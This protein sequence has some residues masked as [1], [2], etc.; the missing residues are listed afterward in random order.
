MRVFNTHDTSGGNVINVAGD[1]TTYT[2]IV[3]NLL[4]KSYAEGASWNSTL[5]CLPG[6]RLEILSEIAA[7]AHTPDSQNVLWLEDV[8]GSGK[9]AIAHTIAQMLHDEGRLASSFFFSRDIASL[10]NPRL[11][12]TTIARDI[13]ALD[14]AIA[15][16]ISNTLE[17][18]PALAF[19]DLS[20]QFEALIAGPLSRSGRQ[21]PFIVVIDAL[22]EGICN[23]VDTH[24]LH[25]LCHNVPRLASRLCIFITSRPTSIIVQFIQNS[26][27]E[28]IKK[29]HINIHSNHNQTDIARYVDAQLRE[30]TIRNVM[31]PTSADE[32]VIRSL[33]AEGLFIWIVTIFNYLR[34][35]GTYRPI[36]K[37][38]ALLSKSSSRGV[39][40]PNKKMDELYAAILK[41]SGDWDDAE[42]R[43]DYALLMGAIISVKRPLSLKALRALHGGDEDLLPLALLQRFGSVLGLHGETEPIHILHISFREFITDCAAPK[44]DTRKYHICEKEHSQR[45]AV[46]CL[47]TMVR[48]FSGHQAS[49]TGYLSREDADEEVCSAEDY[50]ER[51]PDEDDV[52]SDEEKGRET[53]EKGSGVDKEQDNNVHDIGS[54]NKGLPKV[55]EVPEQLLY[56]CESWIG[57]TCDVD[58]PNDTLAEVI[59]EFLLHHNTMWI[60]IVSS[61]SVFRGSLSMLHWLEAH[62]P[63]LRELYDEKSQASA[64][65]SLSKRFAYAGRLEEALTAIQESVYLYELLVAKQPAIFNAGLAM[66]MNS[67]SKCL[68]EV[69]KME[70]ALNA[71][72]KAVDLHR[73]LSLAQTGG[74]DAKLASSLNSLAKTRATLGHHE[75][76]LTAAKESVDLLVVLAAEQPMMFNADLAMT[77]N[78]MSFYLSNLG[79]DEEALPAAEDSVDLYRTLA[80]QRPVK[81][82]AE[83]ALSLNGFS[84]IL[85]TLGR[86]AEALAEAQESVNLYRTL[87]AERPSVFND[88][89][90]RS[91][92]N[93]SARLSDFGRSE[94]ALSAI[95]EAVRLHRNLAAERPAKFNGDLATSLDNL[96]SALSNLGR[97][98][99]ALAPVQEAVYLCR[100]LATER[101]EAFNGDLARSL[102]NVSTCLDSLGRS[103][104]AFPAAQEAVNL[105][106]A[107][108]VKRPAK[109]RPVLAMSLNSLSGILSN[110]G[111][112][113]AALKTI[114]ESVFGCRALAAQRPSVFNA[115]LARSL[116]NMSVYLANLGRSED[117]LLVI[118]ESVFLHRHLAT[119]RPEKYNAELA[120]ALNGLSTVLSNMSWAEAALT[121]VLESVDLRRALA[122]ER[123]AMFAANLA[124]SLCDM[125]LYLENLHRSEEALP[126][127]KEAV[128]LIRTLAAERPET[129][130]AQLA[131]AL[132]SFSDALSNMGR[133][134]EALAAVQESVYLLQI[135]ATERP[136]VFEADFAMALSSMSLCLSNLGRIE[137]AL[138]PIQQAVY[139]Y[140][141]LAANQSTIYS[142]KLAESLDQLSKILSEN[143]CETEAKAV[144]EEL[145]HFGL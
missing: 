4:E 63:E 59:R 46:L 137:E 37:L 15:E 14:A 44:Q 84:E 73:D 54:I 9:S 50:H 8:A 122:A 28:H 98:E 57:H 20:R 52:K 131:L 5:S 139:L 66:S 97:H 125:S 135:L 132:N 113:E 99:K 7:W 115:D 111:Q 61:I 91:L 107:L 86:H 18:E 126:V 64:L 114:T 133:P 83:L 80:T 38:R 68:A 89:L 129:Y 34:S 55:T 121:A 120:T 13:A 36:R 62:A 42:F 26:G 69:G 143:G 43:E 67:L 19:A 101:P 96:S 127:I 90:A 32:A 123:P 72:Q 79:R 144:L 33:K 1:S 45:L 87:V 53:H 58:D 88:G 117:A 136:V 141:I 124:Q 71:A 78:H 81:F 51:I 130:N 112:H 93:M 105:H 56:C 76:A 92:G 3:T 22:D 16:D 145:D 47:Q 29:L 134:E 138:P 100:A 85:S 2:Q 116:S 30:D 40:E 70:E 48:E 118:Q 12:F 35:T 102:L 110:L 109:F 49:G 6:T 60:E 11:I 94:E 24:F 140:R 23:D 39:L 17:N 95:Q 75:A 104:E 82:K 41:E 119:E 25:I 103:E 31:G 10:N 65:F 77:L 142:V 128:K 27:A 21:A 74:C 108:V 106:R